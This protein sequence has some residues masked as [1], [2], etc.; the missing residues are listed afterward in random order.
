MSSSC[1][2]SNKDDITRITRPH[3]VL[4]FVDSKYL[5]VFMNWLIYYID[6]CGEYSNIELIC[7]DS[8]VE[9]ELL[10][11]TGLH[12]SKTLSFLQKNEDSYTTSPANLGLIWLKRM[13]IVQ[14]YIKH[15]DIIFSDSDALWIRNPFEDLSAYSASIISSRAW[16][17][18]PLF[19][20]WGACICMGFFYARSDKF[21]ISFFHTLIT[22]MKGNFSSPLK[23]GPP[24]DQIAVNDLLKRWGV[25]WPY[26]LSVGNSY[27]HD[28]GSVYRNKR[29]NLVVLLSHSKYPRKCH[30]LALR[31]DGSHEA[32]AQVHQTLKNA[33]VAH[34]RVPKG[35]AVR[36]MFRL[37]M[38]KLWR[39]KDDWREIALSLKNAAVLVNRKIPI[40]ELIQS[41]SDK[42]RYI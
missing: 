26:K 36:K 35:S 2:I 7:L 37:K 20:D 6:V 14:E 24:D 18:W 30:S 40:E 28:T 4:M 23:L 25:K 38:Y 32:V 42:K 31:Y 34:C 16:W 41:L 11:F 15:Y 17:P 22:D 19:Q 1:R 10:E 33:T 27:H 12:C 13:E 9:T 29:K 5:D 39:L 8:N 3:R 21:G